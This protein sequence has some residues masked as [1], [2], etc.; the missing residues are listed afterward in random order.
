MK[1]YKKKNVKT[2]HKKWKKKKKKKK[3]HPQEK[4]KI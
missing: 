3:N 2:N 1:Q 4:I